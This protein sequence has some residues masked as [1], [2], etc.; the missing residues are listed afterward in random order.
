MRIPDI[1]D[2]MP[3]WYWPVW[4][5]AIVA[6]A[7]AAGALGFAI[8]YSAVTAGEFFWRNPESFAYGVLIG[9]GLWAGANR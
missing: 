1:E 7:C 5:V 2:D 3:W 8:C 4:L 6:A 9:L